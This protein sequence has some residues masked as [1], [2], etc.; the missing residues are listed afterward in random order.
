MSLHTPEE[1]THTRLVYTQVARIPFDVGP[2]IAV[3]KVVEYR[4]DVLDSMAIL[5][6]HQARFCRLRW[7]G[8]IWR[9]A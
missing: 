9:H 3:P 8:R 6:H 1:I 4:V 2:K 5:A 7:R